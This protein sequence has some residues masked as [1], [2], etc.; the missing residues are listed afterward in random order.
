MVSRR[1]PTTA[2][3]QPQPPAE[4]SRGGLPSEETPAEDTAPGAVTVNVA[5]NELP[6][7]APRKRA[8]RRR[9]PRGSRGA[10]AEAG[11]TIEPARP[12]EGDNFPGGENSDLLQAVQQW[13]RE[14]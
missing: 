12:Q 6:A 10:K 7:K 8:P 9:A 11:E 2:D 14:N 5:L 1:K 3:E 4:V 13:A